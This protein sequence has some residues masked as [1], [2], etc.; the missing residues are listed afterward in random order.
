[1]GKLTAK[2]RQLLELLA[3]FPGGKTCYEDYPDSILAPYWD[4]NSG[5]DDT[6]N[7][8]IDAGLILATVDDTDSGFAALTDAGRAALSAQDG[9][10][11]R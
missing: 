10:S 3:S 2:M 11:G 5:G 4:D 6:F 1:M 8:A 9:E 7:Q